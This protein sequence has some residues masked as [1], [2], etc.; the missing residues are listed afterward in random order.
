[1]LHVHLRDP[2]S[3]GMRADDPLRLLEDPPRVDRN[4]SDRLAHQLD[5]SRIPELHLEELLGEDPEAG[6]DEPP[7]GSVVLAGAVSDDQVKGARPQRLQH[8]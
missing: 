5:A 6:R 1:M 3:Q 4:A 8:R 2:V 7:V